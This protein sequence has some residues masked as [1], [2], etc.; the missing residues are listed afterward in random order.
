MSALTHPPP[1]VWRLTG[2][3]CLHGCG[4]RLQTGVS[5]VWPP[6][7][8]CRRPGVHAT[9]GMWSRRDRLHAVGGPV[10]MGARA[11]RATPPRRRPRRRDRAWAPDPARPTSRASAAG[12]IRPSS[13]FRSATVRTPLAPHAEAGE[14]R[15]RADLGPLRGAPLGSGAFTAV[16]RRC[17]RWLFAVRAHPP[18]QP[19]ACGCTTLRQVVR[20]CAFRMESPA[21]GLP[22]SWRQP[23][24]AWTVREMRRACRA[25]RPGTMRCQAVAEDCEARCFAGTSHACTSR[26]P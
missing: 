2:A 12:P 10:P 23:S 5:S 16:S 1:D 8:G 9:T 22:T 15:V 18:L 20:S 19:G 17:D 4:D 24:E 11:A 14:G 7:A 25:L 3:T 13:N 6:N 21:N 26:R